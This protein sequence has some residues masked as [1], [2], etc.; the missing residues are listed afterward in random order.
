MEELSRRIKEL[1]HKA[2]KFD[3]FEENFKPILNE[4]FNLTEQIQKKL[5]LINP[6]FKVQSYSKPR[7][8]GE[9]D[10]RLQ[11]L[12]AELK[13]NDTLQITISDIENKFNIAQ[14]SAHLLS[15]GLRKM[16]GIQTRKEGITMYFY[17][18]KPKINKDETEIS[19]DFKIPTKVSFMK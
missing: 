2:I 4:I 12:Y 19:P 9:F 10:N 17:Y 13:N 18:F 5:Q 6:L 8:M 16:E 3:D 15:V 14:T 11:Q 1:E 7:I